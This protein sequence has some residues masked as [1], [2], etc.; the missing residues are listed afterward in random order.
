MYFA[1]QCRLAENTDEK[2]KVLRPTH[3]KFMEANKDRILCGG[4]TIGLDGQL[5]IMLIILKGKDITDAET[6]MKTE[7]YN[8]AGVFQEVIIREWRQVLPE[9]EP[10]ALLNE[11]DHA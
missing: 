7:P 1:I 8:Q 6:F 2:R 3:L 10:G 9:T 4:P 11:I 5:E